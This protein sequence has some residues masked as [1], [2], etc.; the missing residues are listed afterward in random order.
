MSITEV[1]KTNRIFKKMNQYPKL[2]GLMRSLFM[3]V[4][5]KKGIIT[6][7]QLHE[8]AQEEMKG[9][10][11]PDTETNYQEYLDGLIDYY[12]A[13]YLTPNEI[14]NYINLARK[15][16]KAQTL[17]MVVNWDQATSL[18]VYHALREFCDIPKG[19]VFISPAEAEGIRVALL[20]R[21]I[22]NQL[23]FV[24]LAKNH[25]VIRDIDA[26]LQRTLWSQ[27]QPGKLGG[28]AAGMVLAHKIL[29]PGI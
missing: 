2:V 19:E 18:E 22:S 14:E 9:D 6:P 25:I 27:K 21:F 12:S 11:V 24:S 8:Q 23:S 3:D 13:N 10:G 15:K 20:S 26:I 4:L 28:K 5:E 1:L 29:L 17:S 16:D 7:D